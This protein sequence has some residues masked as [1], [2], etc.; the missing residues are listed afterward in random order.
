[1]KFEIWWVW[2]GLA[3]VFM[4]GEI[5]TAGFF[6]IF[7][8]I[9]SAAAGILALLGV[10]RPAQLIVFIIVS[11]ILFVFGSRFA[12]RVTEKQPPGIGADRFIGQKGIVLESIDNNTN[13]GSVRIN[14]DKWRAISESGD[15][16]EEGT[17]VEVARI[18]GTRAV[19]KT[20]EK[21]EN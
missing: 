3:A 13:S 10:G 21:E 18:N 19:V 2:M 12:D 8:S 15:I 20:I 17:S 9:G 7:L 5:F 14:Q 16:I 1:M 11:G 4:I 6:L